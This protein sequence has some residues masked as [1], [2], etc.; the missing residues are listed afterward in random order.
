MRITCSRDELAHGLGVV[1]RAMSSRSAVQILS[2]ILLDAEGDELRLAATDMEVSLR[3]VVPASVGEGGSVVV[4]GRLLV[5]LVRLLPE[6]EVA[7]EHRLEEN[8][9]QI[10]SG[11]AEYRLRTY[12]VEDFPRL[13]ETGSAELHSVEAAPLLET[14]GRVGRAAS[15][16]ESR[17]VL[18][19]I[20]VRFEQGKL[21]MAA[22][23]SYRLS[24]KETPLETDVPELEAIVPARALDELRRV[25]S[26]A[27][28]IQL[29]VHENQV[30]FGVGDVWLTTRRIDGQFPN[31][32]TLIPEAFE[33]EVTM[34]REELLE[35]VRRTA[36]MAQR[37]APLRLRFAEGELTVSS[38]TQ[39][40]GES[41]ETLPVPFAGE[42][43]E[44]GFNPEFLRDGIESVT[45]DSL[46]L[47]L[48]NPLRPGLIQGTGRDF[49][50]LI[51]PIRLAG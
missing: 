39:D 8:T 42:P 17:P 12:A 10:T 49:S 27:E 50:Y 48:I 13:P 43:L 25:A 35:V 47:R 23:D 31:Y 26:G 30:V 36:V 18:T 38:Q 34:P 21:V 6:N 32:R 40:V 45:G 44:I 5:D 3:T 14:I 4:P 20:L 22:T 51:M 37:N 15:R 33:H 2:G 29:G 28:R 7:V 1:V 11:Q 46:V 16:D 9:L 19:G 41:R 24:V